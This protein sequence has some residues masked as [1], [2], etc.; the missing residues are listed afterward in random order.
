[1]FTQLTIHDNGAGFKK[2]IYHVYLTDFIV[3]KIQAQ[4]VM[5]IGLALCKT[6][7]MRQGG[8]ITAQNH[9]QGGAIFVI[10]FPK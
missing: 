4:P 2:K 3:G 6:I 7:I 10:R 9:P 8:T 1:M 5:E